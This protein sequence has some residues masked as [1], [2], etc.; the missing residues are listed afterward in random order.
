VAN[1]IATAASLMRSGSCPESFNCLLN[2]NIR[3]IESWSWLTWG[4]VV[5][6]IVKGCDECRNIVSLANLVQVASCFRNG[7]PVSPSKIELFSYYETRNLGFD[8]EFIAYER[9]T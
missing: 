2:R 1:P 7:I 6:V 8:D 5:A 9:W 4:T 3:A